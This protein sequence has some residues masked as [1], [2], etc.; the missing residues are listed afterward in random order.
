MLFT[1][2]FVLI[3]IIT[4]LLL[5]ADFYNI[6]NISGRRLVGLRWWNEVNPASG[7]TTMVFE[8][9]PPEE[10]ATRI[11]ATDRRFFWL[12]L[13]TQP[14]LWFAV[15]I[16]AIA[17]LELVWLTL[18][19]IALVLTITNTVAF[20]RCDRF[21]QANSAVSRALMGGGIAGSLA[22]GIVGR[23]FG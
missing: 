21:S 5:A 7:D 14:L 1:S 23:L 4:M 12:A 17:K 20:S 10:A 19:I 18:V 9:L 8:S 15:G 13:Y 3:F 16:V 2:N 11:N 22:N 6:K